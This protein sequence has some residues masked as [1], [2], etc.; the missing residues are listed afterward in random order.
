MRADELKDIVTG[1]F[2][3]PFRLHLSNGLTIDVAQPDLI[4][5]GRSIAWVGSPSD[6]PSMTGRRPR[7]I[8]LVH[9]IWLE[10]IDGPGGHE[11]N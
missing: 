7:A 5:L 1:R 9:I 3:H 10:F 2:F 6:H 4:V 11:L 8:S